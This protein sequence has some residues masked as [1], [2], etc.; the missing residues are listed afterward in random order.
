M[1]TRLRSIVRRTVAGACTVAGPPP[2]GLRILTYHRVNRTHPGDRLS[3]HPDAFAAQMEWLV[4]SGRP[5]V[6]LAQAPSALRGETALAPGAVALTFDDG[7]ADNFTVALP[8]LERHRLPA[9]FFLATSFVGAGRTLDRYQGCCS[10]DRMLDWE[11][12]RVLG[13]GRHALG[14]HGC[15]HRELDAL[16]ADDARGEIEGCARAIET[17]TGRRPRL[18]CY[19]RGRETPQTRGLVAAAGFE[20]ACT[21]RPGANPAGADLLALARTEVSGDDEIEDFRAKLDGAFDRWH[22]LRQAMAR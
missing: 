22:R 2:E 11:E 4:R 8:I 1:R 21:V 17:A 15:T 19:P 6:S 20:A 13:G 3:V 16:A 14:G 18:F 12:A 7:F 5:V 9:T 10:D